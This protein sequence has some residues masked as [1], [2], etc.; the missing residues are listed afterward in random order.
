[1]HLDDG[2]QPVRPE[3]RGKRIA[4]AS[5]VRKRWAR[6][7]SPT[8]TAMAPIR[9]VVRQVPWRAAGLNFER[10]G[11]PPDPNSNEGG[12]LPCW[13][14]ELSQMSNEIR[15]A[16]RTNPEVLASLQSRPTMAA[17]A[18][19]RSFIVRSTAWAS[20]SASCAARASSPR[21]SAVACPCVWR[22]EA[23]VV[24]AGSAFRLTTAKI[25]LHRK[26]QSILSL[27]D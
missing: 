18:T 23:S 10:G 5:R 16:Y 17:R 11:D 12:R 14:S 27:F 8:G 1:M 22:E 21:A 9:F 19:S 20:G 26:Y 13:T 24:R 2:T 3:A 6:C 4:T 7:S 25:A 15:S